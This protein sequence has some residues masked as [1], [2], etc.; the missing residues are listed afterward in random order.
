MFDIYERE[1][2]DPLLGLKYVAD[3]DRLVTL[4]R[5]AGLA[6]RPGAAFKMTVGRQ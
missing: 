5:L 4:Q 1:Y 6:H 2:K 3:P